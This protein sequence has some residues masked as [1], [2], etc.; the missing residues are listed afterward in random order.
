MIRSTECRHAAVRHCGSLLKLEPGQTNSLTPFDPFS[1][2]DLPFLSLA[3]SRTSTAVAPATT[4][5]EHYSP[6]GGM[7]CCCSSLLLSV[8]PCTAS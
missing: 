3:H 6:P 1:E 7:S 2:Q 5:P 4:L 8:V